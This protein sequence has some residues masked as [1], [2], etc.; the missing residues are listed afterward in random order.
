MQSQALSLLSSVA[1]LTLNDVLVDALSHGEKLLLLVARAS[2]D[3]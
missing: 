2:L 3:K 1:Y